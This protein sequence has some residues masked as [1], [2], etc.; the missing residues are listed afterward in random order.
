MGVNILRETQRT[1]I[2][3]NRL[4]LMFVVG[5]A[6]G[7]CST[8]RTATVNMIGDALS[9]GVGVY[10]SDNDP[11]LIREA[12]P[13]GLKTYES[14]L[15]VS[16][17]HRGLL[18]ASANGFAAYAYLLGQEADRLDGVDLAAAREKR[19][20]SKLLFLRGRDYAIR[21]LETSH[22][23]FME[24]L[25]RER[26]ATIAST[27]M[28]DVAFLYWAGA[29]WAGALSVAKDDPEL[30]ADL[31]IAGALVTRVLELDESYDN[32]SAHEFF[33]SYE[34]GRPGGDNEKARAHY[35]R[36]YELSAGR[37]ASVHVALAEAVVV[38]EQN[39]AEFR[40]L[41]AAALAVEPDE[42]PEI[43]L[44]NTIAKRRAEWLET[45]IP[46]LFVETN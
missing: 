37:K 26:D 30:I 40:F 22:P 33:I 23:N 29:S 45:Q 43:R 36:A 20:R 44:V 18:L 2:I 19:A 46:R 31:P 39:L 6:I 4:L 21:G 8:V 42:A 38:S 1:R 28:E 13:F 9:G 15:A 3:L 11:D 17:E 12:L 10:M 34:G 35:K 24:G 16:P 41:I 7:G 25:Y 5:A 32:G 27:K 14:L